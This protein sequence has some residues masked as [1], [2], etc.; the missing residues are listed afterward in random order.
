VFTNQKSEDPNK[1]NKIL[2]KIKKIRFKK[3][4]FRKQNYFQCIAME[5]MIW[6]YKVF[7]ASFVG[8]ASGHIQ[9]NAI[10]GCVERVF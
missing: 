9:Q 7:F 4:Y 10:K 8:Q 3:H 6:S 1:I 2:G 5:K